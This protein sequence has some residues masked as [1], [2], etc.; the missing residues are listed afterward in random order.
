MAATNQSAPRNP[1]SKPKSKATAPRG[2]RNP[3]KAAPPKKC[4]ALAAGKAV[5]L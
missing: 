5:T 4:D 3:A 1:K 2:K